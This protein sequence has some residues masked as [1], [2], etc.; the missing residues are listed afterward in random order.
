MDDDWAVGNGNSNTGADTG[1]LVVNRLQ[2]KAN[3]CIRDWGYNVAIAL[4]LLRM[5]CTQFIRL[6]SLCSP[7]QPPFSPLNSS[8]ETFK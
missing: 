1:N 8:P 3:N 4:K 6:F 2:E 7:S 5:S